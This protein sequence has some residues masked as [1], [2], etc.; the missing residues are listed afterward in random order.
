MAAE[1]SR[2]KFLYTW[3]IGNP[4]CL[5]GLSSSR[6]NGLHGTVVVVDAG[7]ERD[8]IGVKIRIDGVER[9]IAV[10]PESLSMAEGMDTD[11]AYLGSIVSALVHKMSMQPDFSLVQTSMLPRGYG[12][13]AHVTSEVWKIST[14]GNDFRYFGRGPQVPQGSFC[15]CKKNART[16]V[17]SG[18][19]RDRYFK[20]QRAH[21]CTEVM[22]FFILALHH[23][24]TLGC[25]LTIDGQPITDVSVVRGKVPM[26]GVNNPFVVPADARSLGDRLLSAR[27]MSTLAD[28]IYMTHVFLQVTAREKKHWI[29]ISATQLDI[30]QHSSMGHPLLVISED[31]RHMFSTTRTTLTERTVESYLESFDLSKVALFS[32]DDFSFRTALGAVLPDGRTINDLALQNAKPRV[33]P[34]RRP[35]AAAPLANLTERTDR[36]KTSVNTL[37]M[38]CGSLLRAGVRGNIWMVVVKDLAA[39]E[40]AAVS[41]MLVRICA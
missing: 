6:F 27:S 22:Y 2:C 4:V 24:R 1:L 28:G 39:A 34:P 23:A 31:Q 21:L 36:F 15:F 13:A 10:K 29:D 5:H 18:C 20:A 32:C 7:K 37:F 41:K 40:A 35:V 17:G 16:W 14:V 38:A 25:R 11:V 33:L 30:F 8:R 9:E 12:D 3:H 19:C 26:A